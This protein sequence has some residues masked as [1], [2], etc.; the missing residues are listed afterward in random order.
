M[1]PVH[2]ARRLLLRLCKDSD[3]PRNGQS[4]KD[5]RLRFVSQFPGR[6]LFSSRY[7]WILAMALRIW[8]LTGPFFS[9]QSIFQVFKQGVQSV[10]NGEEI[11]IEQEVLCDIEEFIVLLA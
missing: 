4:G 7:F 2:T 10:V 8:V 6:R 9:A 5:G 3:S 1:I 11:L